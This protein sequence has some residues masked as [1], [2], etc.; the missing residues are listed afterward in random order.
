MNDSLTRFGPPT[1]GKDE[2]TYPN[3][4][5]QINIDDY[6]YFFNFIDTS[7]LILRYILTAFIL[8]LL[9]TALFIACCLYF[10]DVGERI[11]QK[12]AHFF[13]LYK[14]T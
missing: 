14:C 4:K 7:T 5:V 13:L 11:I 3:I 8:I 6:V 12:K 10:L 2:Q 9:S 1:R